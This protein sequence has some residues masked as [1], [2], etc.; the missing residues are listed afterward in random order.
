MS[1]RRVRTVTGSLRLRL[2]LT[3]AAVVIIPLIVVVV[4]IGRWTYSNTEQ[5]SLRIQQQVAAEVESEGSSEG[6]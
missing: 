5:Q 3:T 4:V 1:R 2:M 6:A